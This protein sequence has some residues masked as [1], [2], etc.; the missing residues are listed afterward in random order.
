MASILKVDTIQDQA[1]NNI[2]SEN[3]NVITIGAS[4]D[5]ITVPAGAT[6]SGFT[7]AGIDDNATSTALKIS[8]GGKIGIGTTSPLKL[9]DVVDSGDPTIQVR[10]SVST[11]GA[12]MRVDGG[13]SNDSFYS[14]VG[15]GTSYYALFRDGSQNQDL[16]LYSYT[17]T[18]GATDI[19]RYS[20]NGSLRFGTSANERMRITSSGNVGINTT[21]PGQ[22]LDV[23]GNAEI[24]GNIYNNGKLN[25]RK[26]GASE[27]EHLVITNE[28]A[29]SNA[30]PTFTDLHFN[31]YSGKDR[32]R[33]RVQDQSNNKVGGFMRIETAGSESTDGSS[34]ETRIFLDND[35]D[36]LF[37]E[38]TGTTAKVKWDATNERFGIGTTA[39]T[40]PLEVSGSALFGGTV[41]ATGS[42]TTTNSRRAIMT[43]DGSSMIFK[44]SGDSTNR[45]IVFER[46]GDGSAD[47]TMRIDSST[48]V[49]VG[50]TSSTGDVDNGRNLS[51][52]RFYTKRTYHT[53]SATNTWE[54]VETLSSNAGTYLLTALGSGGG[55][56]TTDNYIGFLSVNGSGT[57]IQDIK[58]AT[59]VQVQMS[60]LNLQIKQQFFPTANITYSL[61]RL[62]N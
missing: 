17:D 13:S 23:V 46:S 9:L 15:S 18:A 10:S 8:S 20:I 53:F 48:N 47:E 33:I 5:T 12:S 24:N 30:S 28:T 14:L 59:D 58:T 1:G 16:R 29:G 42:T 37:Y 45:N 61:L 26:D 7:S 11:T 54:T 31:G 3:A 62:N 6:V 55:N 60:G 52:G 4:G 2:I 25:I 19:L 36:I 38:D 40:L 57:H 50:T 43:H 49:L 22:A 39:P 56:P 35:G 44:A 34:F 21:S 41:I 32:A 27:S 51:A